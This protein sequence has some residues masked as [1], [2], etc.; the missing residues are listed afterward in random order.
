MALVDY[1]SSEDEAGCG[2]E[3]DFILPPFVYD[4][5]SDVV[6]FA[7]IGRTSC[8]D[9]R[10]RSFAH[11]HGNWATCVF[12]PGRMNFNSTRLFVGMIVILLAF[13]SYSASV[14][15]GLFFNALLNNVSTI[16]SQCE[17]RFYT[18]EDFHLS[19]TKIWPIL[20]HWIASFT[21]AVRGIATK[22]QRFHITLGEAGFLVNEDKTRLS[23]C[24]GDVGGI[25]SPAWKKTCLTSIDHF[26]SSRAPLEGFE[27]ESLVL[28]IGSDKYQLPLL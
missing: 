17:Q 8:S 15:L 6:R 16:L 24:L 27:L 28:K 23:W 5:K 13:S 20:H 2:N 10:V 3:H 4:A 21:E 22:Y 1:S 7:E 11:R 18:C 26:I 19:L 12:L 14:P 9:G 25:L